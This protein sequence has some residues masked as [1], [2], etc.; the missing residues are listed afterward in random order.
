MIMSIPRLFPANSMAPHGEPYNN[1][2]EMVY[3]YIHS[4]NRTPLLVSSH[5]LGHLPGKK[6][7]IGKVLDINATN[8]LVDIEDNDAYNFILENI[9]TAVIRVVSTCENSDMEYGIR[10]TSIRR[11]EL[12]LISKRGNDDD[13]TIDT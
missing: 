11:I 3:S 2:Q 10:V 5:L 9:D 7:S 12:D 13:T 4:R 8:F 1:M 6:E